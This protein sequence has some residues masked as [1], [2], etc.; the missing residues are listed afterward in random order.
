MGLSIPSYWDHINLIGNRLIFNNES[1]IKWFLCHSADLNTQCESGL[2]LTSLSVAV[3]EAPFPII[4]LLFDHSGSIKH[5]QLVHYAVRW[6]M[7][8]HLKVLKFLID[9]GTSINHVMYH[10]CPHCYH[11][12]SAFGLETSLHK[13]AEKG[14]LNVVK[15]LLKRDT[16]SLIKNL[17]EKL[18]IER[19]EHRA[20]T[21]V[22]EHLHSLSV[23]S[24]LHC[25]F[26]DEHWIEENQPWRF[27][28][29]VL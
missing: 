27:H 15:F 21:A 26:S 5:S 18:A 7:P 12:Q 10:D 1:L 29:Y 6:N 22:A 13:A 24:E 2:N 19:A 23:S 25:D 3:F 8:N 14:K 20:H 11:R 16:D 17:R 28:V 4:K 9:K